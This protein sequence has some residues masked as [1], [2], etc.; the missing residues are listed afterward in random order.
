MARYIKYLFHLGKYR[1]TLVGLW[2]IF[3]FLEDGRVSLH[4]ALSQ[5]I[6][7]RG[8]TTRALCTTRFP[9]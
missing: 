8:Y 4:L 3:F 2:M 7:A 9:R 1:A 5:S 6:A